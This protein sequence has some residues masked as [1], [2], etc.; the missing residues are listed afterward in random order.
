[1]KWIGYYCNL[2]EIW[3]DIF[4]KKIIKGGLL[5]LYVSFIGI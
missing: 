3:W 2:W 4:L 1:M 5:I